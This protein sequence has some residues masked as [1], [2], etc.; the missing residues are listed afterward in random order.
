MSA[1]S[2]S[3]AGKDAAAIAVEQSINIPPTLRKHQGSL[4][5]IFVARDL[6]FSGVYGLRVTEG[7]TRIFDRGVSGDF[8]PDSG[9]VTK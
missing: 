9:L 1:E 4:I 7:R 5:N 8:S 6:D 3:N 2:T